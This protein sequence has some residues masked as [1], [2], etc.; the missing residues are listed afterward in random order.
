MAKKLTSKKARMILK[1]GKVRGKKIS[2]KQQK[3]FG[4]IASG[5]KPHK[6]AMHKMP[7]GHMMKNSE[8]NKMIKKAMS[9]GR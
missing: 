4:A 2:R 3:F 6:E 7:G 8:M 9:K 5:E 1:D